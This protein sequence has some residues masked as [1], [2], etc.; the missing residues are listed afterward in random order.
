V[1]LISAPV[2]SLI[3]SLSPD[4]R[5]V[6]YETFNTLTNLNDFAWTPATGTVCIWILDMLRV[7]PEAATVVP[8]RASLGD[9]EGNIATTGYFGGIP[10]GRYTEKDGCGLLKTDGLYRS[11]IG[12]DSRHTRGVACNYDPLSAHLAV[13]T[14]DVDRRAVYLNQEWDCAMDP[15][16]GDVF[17]AYNDGPLED[18][19]IMGPFSELESGSPAAFLAPGQ[20]ISHRHSVFHLTGADRLSSVAVKAIMEAL[21]GII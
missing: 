5:M 15:L 20:T 14:F 17:N 19:S 6:A 9:R 3:P 18:G 1:R 16:R 4:I 12:L 2:G 8:F 10:D 7:S 21:S 11:K 13:A